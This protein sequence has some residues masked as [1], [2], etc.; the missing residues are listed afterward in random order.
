MILGTI[1]IYASLFVLNGGICFFTT[2]SLEI[3]NIFTDGARDLTQ[4]PL[5]IF[6]KYVKNFFTYILPLAFVATAPAHAQDWGSDS[7][8]GSSSKKKKTEPK[9][10]NNGSGKSDSDNKKTD[11]KNKKTPKDGQEKPNKNSARPS[12][13]QNYS[14]FIMSDKPLSMDRRRYACV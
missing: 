8:W 10:N 14:L 3:M 11:S 13:N 6:H 9:K 1:V 2:Q 7:G 4:Y 12:F 5:S